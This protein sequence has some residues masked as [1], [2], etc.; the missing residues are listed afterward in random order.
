MKLYLKFF[1]FLFC[2]NKLSF[3]FFSFFVNIGARRAAQ[4]KL[5]HE[6]GIKPEKVPLDDFVFLTRIH[7]LAPSDGLWGE[8]EGNKII[9]LYNKY[10]NITA[11][12]LIFPSYFYF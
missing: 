7:Y 8:H 5:E 10:N 1:K 12:K 9:N 2:F 6:L 3:L 4:R 11:R